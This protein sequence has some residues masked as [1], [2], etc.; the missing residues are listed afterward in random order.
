MATAADFFPSNYL[1]ST[2]LKGKEVVV[3]I[4]RVESD[5]FENDGKKQVKPVIHFRDS[6]VKPL[7]CNKTNFVMIAA[8]CGPDSD[9]WPGKQIVLFGDLVPFKGTVT[10]AVRVKRAASAAPKPEFSDAVPF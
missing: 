1:R 5:A 8:A 10:E 9:S 3:T 4:D 2:D 7:V 6:G